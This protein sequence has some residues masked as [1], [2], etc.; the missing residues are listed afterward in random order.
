MVEVAELFLGMFREDAGIIV[1]SGIGLFV[2]ANIWV[3]III[4]GDIGE[5]LDG[6]GSGEGNVGVWCG[7]SG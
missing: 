6:A 7:C 5:G 2:V 1:L 3:V 4:K